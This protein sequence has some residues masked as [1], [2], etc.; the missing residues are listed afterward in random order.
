MELAPELDAEIG[1][2]LNFGYFPYLLFRTRRP[3]PLHYLNNHNTKI[4][5]EEK[6]PWALDLR[7]RMNIKY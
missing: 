3:A 4:S 6:A 5:K 2:I 7:F 1:N